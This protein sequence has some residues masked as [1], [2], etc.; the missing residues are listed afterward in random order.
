MYKFKNSLFACAGVLVLIGVVS[1]VSPLTGHGQTE[2]VSSVKPVLPVR[3]VDNPARQPFSHTF[4][5][6]SSIG[7]AT[8]TV[9]P[10]SQGPFTVPAGK[11][12]VIED[13]SA[14]VLLPVGQR[15]QVV[16]T[17]RDPAPVATSRIT[18]PLTLT[19]QL[20]T[21]D[22]P[23]R[24]VFVAGEPV[25]MY[26]EPGERLAAFFV[27]SGTNDSGVAQVYVQGYFVDLPCK[28]GSRNHGQCVS[29]CQACPAGSVCVNGECLPACGPNGECPAGFTCDPTTGACIAL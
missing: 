11:R 17:V 28:T 15:A 14:Q 6:I 25:R 12:L 9:S 26:L 22:I 13:A 23:A 24:D 21:L 4:G 27:R 19:F 29:A 1:L 8:G 3:D 7:S 10:E 5:F 18:R 20:T 2:T 16:L